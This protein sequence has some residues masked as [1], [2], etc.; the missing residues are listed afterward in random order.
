MLMLPVFPQ[1]RGFFTDANIAMISQCSLCVFSI[2]QCL[3]FNS[4]LSLLT[5]LM[6]F[7]SSVKVLIDREVRPGDRSKIALGD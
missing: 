4:L 6:W 7:L 3:I 2:V 1:L 5:S